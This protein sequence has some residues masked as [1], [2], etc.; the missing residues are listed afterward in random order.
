MR[1]TACVA[2][3]LALLCSAGAACRARTSDLGRN[4][5][6]FYRR[7]FAAF[8][9]VTEEE[10]SIVAAY[11]PGFEPKLTPEQRP[12]LARRWGSFHDLARYGILRSEWAV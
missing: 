3:A 7:A 4:A 6:L 11:R 12:D 9:E 8:P 5:A 2:A 1:T 10:S